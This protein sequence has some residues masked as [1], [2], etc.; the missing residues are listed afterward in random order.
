MKFE[1]LRGPRV[2]RSLF[3]GI[4]EFINNGMGEVG[5]DEEKKR[6][7]KRNGLFSKFVR[8]KIIKYSSLLLNIV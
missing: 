8:L 1:L 4:K 3:F 6:M 5:E 2:S 7:E